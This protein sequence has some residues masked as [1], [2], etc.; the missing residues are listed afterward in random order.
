MK[1]SC[2]LAAV[3]A[4]V[5]AA[6]SDTLQEDDPGELPTRTPMGVWGK[7]LVTTSSGQ[8]VAD[9]LLVRFSA[10]ATEEERRAAA[11]DV[12]AELAYRGT[13]TGYDVLRFPDQAALERGLLALRAHAAPASAP[14]PLVSSWPC[15][16][17]CTPSS[18]CP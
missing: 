8:V 12:G 4:V 7:P 17:T 9:E 5:S 10:D 15:S 2:W 11:E 6:C 14:R 18:S 13:R 3:V 16:G 1:Y